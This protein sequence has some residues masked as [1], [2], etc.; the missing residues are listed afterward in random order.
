MSSSATKTRYLDLPP[1]T[2]GAKPAF[3]DLATVK[4]WIGDLPVENARA[5]NELLAKQIGLFASFDIHPDKRLD[6]LE[7]LRPSVVTVQDEHAKKYRG[8][9]AP[10]LPHRRETL[11]EVTA[12]WETLCHAYQRCLDGWARNDKG[13]LAGQAQALQRALDSM[14]RLMIEHYY[15][16]VVPPRSLYRTLHRL[17]AYG[18]R[19]GFATLK[20]RDAHSDIPEVSP[21]DTYVRTLLFDAALPREHRPHVLAI[22]FR[23][24]ATWTEKVKVGQVTEELPGEVPPLYTDLAQDRGLRHTQESGEGVRQFEMDALAA[25]IH[26]RLHHLRHGHNPAETD[27]GAELSTREFETLLIALH[28]QWCEGTVK[29]QFERQ[30][31]EALAHVSTGLPA[32]HFYL[33]R[34]PFRQPF[35][36]TP[37]P[38]RRRGKI[39]GTADRI[40]AATDYL[41]GS[42]IIAEQWMVRDESLTGIGLIRPENETGDAWLTHGLLIAVRPRGGNNALVGTIQWL[43]EAKAGDLHVG[44]RLLPGVPSA[45]AARGFGDEEFF[46]AIL[47]LPLPALATPSSIVVPPGTF[48]P[49]R[50][51]DIF[52]QGINRIQLTALLEGGIDFERVAFMPAGSV[53]VPIEVEAAP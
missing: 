47:L 42:N 15:A 13:T 49:Q 37:L 7:A 20:V 22:V 19:F 25:T 43:E 29:R 30:P 51:L 4:R 11:S 40:K 33:S 26:D 32:A 50:V 36:P 18:E 5:A 21:R 16:Y 46:P 34:Q 1:P 35:A 39:D 2:P 10:L 44:V 12:L 45:I 23:L 6:V 41:L 17:Y 9:P 14:A 38:P 31:T 27:L 48:A 24:L 52:R 53:Y 28:R 3:N 8:K